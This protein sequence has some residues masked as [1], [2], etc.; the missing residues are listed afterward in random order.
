[1]LC[2]TV[3]AGGVMEGVVDPMLAGVG[4]GAAALRLLAEDGVA[5]R[6]IKGEDGMGRRGWT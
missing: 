4:D 6:D 5:A 3:F 1:M 2:A